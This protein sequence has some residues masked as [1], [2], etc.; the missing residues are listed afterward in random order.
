MY[1][2]RN[3]YYT[4]ITNI[5]VGAGINGVNFTTFQKAKILSDAEGYLEIFDFEQMEA[6][7]INWN[8]I[9]AVKRHASKTKFYIKRDRYSSAFDKDVCL[10]LRKKMDECTISQAES[11][12]IK[13]FDTEKEAEEYMHKHIP[14]GYKEVDYNYHYLV[15]EE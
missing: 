3:F 2:D 13:L 4:I 6:L 9:V 12:G 14:D 5:A 8:S 15:K 11:L 1:L 7:F 10:V